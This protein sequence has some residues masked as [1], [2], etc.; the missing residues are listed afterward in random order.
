MNTIRK[1]R[2]SLILKDLAEMPFFQV[3]ENKGIAFDFCKHVQKCVSDCKP[4]V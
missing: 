1:T 4:E 3:V 2:K